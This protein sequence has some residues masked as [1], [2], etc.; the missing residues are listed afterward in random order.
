MGLLLLALLVGFTVVATAGHLPFFPIGV[1]TTP[2]IFQPEFSFCPGDGMVTFFGN[3]PPP[4]LSPNCIPAPGPVRCAIQPIRT[5]SM[6]QGTICRNKGY[7]SGFTK[8]PQEGNAFLKCCS[9][10]DYTYS[11]RSC[12][13]RIRTAQILGSNLP[14]WYLPVGGTP[15]RNAPGEVVKYCVFVRRSRM[16]PARIRKRTIIRR[17]Y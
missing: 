1:Y 10:M 9:S 7:V 5:G 13:R 12:V 16:S 2:E 8:L 4:L 3:P 14:P 6:P 11:E 17:L 15:L